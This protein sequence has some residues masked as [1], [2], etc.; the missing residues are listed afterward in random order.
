MILL[1]RSTA[2]VT[3]YKHS[4]P[5]H[6]LSIGKQQMEGVAEMAFE[7]QLAAMVMQMAPLQL[8]RENEK[9]ADEMHAIFL[10]MRDWQLAV[11]MHNQKALAKAGNTAAVASLATLE[12]FN[13]SSAGADVI[14]SM[15]LSFS[16]EFHYGTAAEQT[17]LKE[18]Q[19]AAHAIIAAAGY[20]VPLVRALQDRVNEDKFASHHINDRQFSDNAYVKSQL[21]KKIE[22]WT[23]QLY[24]IMKTSSAAHAV[25][26][27][28]ARAIACNR[29][30]SPGA[31]L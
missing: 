27:E 31:V 15:D 12:C 18:R 4:H 26:M 22:K 17:A 23:R 7:Q 29:V 1:L 9:I 2:T 11:T 21:L 28:K 20:D 6:L 14:H 13:S 16:F 8:A 19:Q 25:T 24:E 10:Y 30:P 5:P 3:G